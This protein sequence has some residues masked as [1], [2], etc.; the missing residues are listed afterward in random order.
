VDWAAYPEQVSARLWR[1]QAAALEGE[2]ALPRPPQRALDEVLRLLRA[3]SATPAADQLTA[4][5]CCAALEAGTAVPGLDWLDGPVLLV[6]G[7]GRRAELAAPVAL[8]VEH[9]DQE[10]LRLLLH[11]LGIAPQRP[12]R[13]A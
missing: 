9:G 11:Q 5:I 13:L 4:L 7:D 1:A 2:L 3:A 6:E 10:P 8:A 12:A